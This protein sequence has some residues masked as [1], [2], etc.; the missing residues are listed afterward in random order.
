[1]GYT[2]DQPDHGDQLMGWAGRLLIWLAVACALLSAAS[3]ASAQAVPR[4]AQRY[5][6]TLKREAQRVWGL[7]APMATFGAQIHQ[8]SRWRSDARSPVGALGL[9]QFMPATADWIGGM[10]A[11]LRER[12]PLNPTWA[13][14][15]LVGVAVRG[16][17]GSEE[18]VEAGVEPGVDVWM[19]IPRILPSC[20]SGSAAGRPR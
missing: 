3:F 2:H 17:R 18:S 11:G 7:D 16:E 5:Q 8:E 4:E 12:A 15:G 20:A 19:L 6:L 1:M 9:A 13:L 10:D 14:R